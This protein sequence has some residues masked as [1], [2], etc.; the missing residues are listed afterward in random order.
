MFK[1]I[2]KNCAIISIDDFYLTSDEQIK[3]ANKYSS[4]PL[5]QYRGNG[6]FFII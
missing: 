5:L 3:L 2:N 4:N 6:F 1:Q